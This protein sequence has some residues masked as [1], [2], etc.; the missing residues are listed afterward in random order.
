M[1]R[2][3]DT[4]LMANH[5]CSN[6]IR[7]NPAAAASIHDAPGLSPE[8]AIGAQLSL[9]VLPIPSSHVKRSRADS[10]NGGLQAD[11]RVLLPQPV[12]AL[13]PPAGKR[14]THLGLCVHLAQDSRLEP[15]RA[16]SRAY[17][18]GSDG[19]RRSGAYQP[20]RAILVPHYRRK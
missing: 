16:Q 20:H 14:V 15:L 17:R 8:F 13:P 6:R 18:S 1:R 3:S 12:L 10:R 19:N 2:E 9:I 7:L 4:Q 5:T 11:A